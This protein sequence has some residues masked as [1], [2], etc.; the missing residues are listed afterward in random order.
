MNEPQLEFAVCGWARGGSRHGGGK[1]VTWD[2]NGDEA[3]LAGSPGSAAVIVI[4]TVV[5][6]MATSIV[7]GSSPNST[8][9]RR[10]FAPRRMAN[11]RPPRMSHQRTTTAP[12]FKLWRSAF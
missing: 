11:M 6:L 3:A 8:S 1:G 10:P 2:R 4:W 5:A 9:C 7:T 12:S